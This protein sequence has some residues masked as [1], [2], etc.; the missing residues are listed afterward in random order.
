MRIKTLKSSTKLL[1]AGLVLIGMIIIVGKVGREAEPPDTDS[2]VVRIETG[3]FGRSMTVDIALP[4]AGPHRVFTVDSP[5]R[6]VVDVSTDIPGDLSPYRLPAQ[7]RGL[8]RLRLPD[9]WTRLVFMLAEP[10]AIHWAELQDRDL[11]AT[12]RIRARRS[13]EAEFAR[14]A[15]LPP[16]AWP[17]AGPVAFREGLTIAI[18]AGHGGIDPGAVREGI[19]E[20]DIV[21]DFGRTLARRLEMLDGVSV[22][23]LRNEDRFMGLRERVAGARQANAD[24]LVSLHANADRDPDISGAIVFTRAERGSSREAAARAL[25]E[26]SADDR[27]GLADLGAGDPVISALSDLARRETDARS[28]ALAR[29][30]VEALRGVAPGTVS[31]KAPL[32]AANF[33]VL[34]APD[35]PSI[36]LEIGFLSNPANRENMLSEEWRDRT[37]TE[38]ARGILTW[39]AMDATPGRL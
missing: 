23:M 7:V 6:L 36:L 31:E 17:I 21:L 11:G 26:N 22:V 24:L 25:L 35:I 33:I 12:L 30:V 8:D 14:D 2:S 13:S 28:Q 10:F 5:R 1:S 15:G 3:L 19:R 9:G 39:V 29:A 34:R 20:K 18:D 32:Q 16:G 4:S 38:V 37:A 27:A